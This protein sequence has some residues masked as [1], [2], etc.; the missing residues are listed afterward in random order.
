MKIGVKG[1]IM[2]RST[3]FGSWRR[4][5]GERDNGRRSEEGK[6]VAM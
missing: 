1:V 6:G 5:K 3:S 4:G 2:K